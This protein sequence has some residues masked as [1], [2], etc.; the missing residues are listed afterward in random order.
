MGDIEASVANDLPSKSILPS[1]LS[2]SLDIMCRS[3][4]SAFFRAAS[5]VS[6]FPQPFHRSAPDTEQTTHTV[7]NPPQPPLQTLEV[8]VSR[9]L[10][11]QPL[12]Q[13]LH[14]L[15][16]LVLRLLQ[17]HLEL[18]LEL[19]DKACYPHREV[20]CETDTLRSN[21]RVVVVLEWS[22]GAS[23]K[24]RSGRVGGSREALVATQEASWSRTGNG[25][26][27]AAGASASAASAEL[28]SLRFRTGDM[29]RR[30]RGRSSSG[31]QQDGMAFGEVESRSGCEVDRDAK[32]RSTGVDVVCALAGLGR[33]GHCTVQS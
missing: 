22:E 28:L 27:Q 5:Q 18:H 11:V 32:R 9:L 16:A 1:E 4:S 33:T 14:A 2:S 12:P 31:R 8:K 10:N 21:G 19:L 25:Y 23:D 7:V 26:G 17:A 30:G 24:A 3:I 13:V 6:T 15:I 29:R 20:L